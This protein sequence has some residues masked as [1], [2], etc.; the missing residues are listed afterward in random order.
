LSVFENLNREKQKNTGQPFTAREG[1][2]VA[3][4]QSTSLGKRTSPRK[5]LRNVESKYVSVHQKG[6]RR[7]TS[8]V[9]SEFFV[10]AC[11]LPLCAAEPQGIPVDQLGKNYRLIGKLQVPLG[12]VVCI[13]GVV[14]EGDDK[15]FEDGPNL[16]VQRIDGKAVQGNIQIKLHPY[17]TDW[18]GKASGEG[19]SLPK[20]E[21][22]K[23]YLMEGYETGRYVGIPTKAY[24]QAGVH[25]QASD[26]IFHTELVVYKAKAVESK[27]IQSK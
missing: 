23:T 12:E 25:R 20:L 3:F 9:A 7:M 10:L 19:H 4:R 22:G 21:S 6:A 26:H 15:G 8:S 2:G 16:R 18:G 13:E 24:K 14:V 11:C 1:H 17:F 27:P 5:P